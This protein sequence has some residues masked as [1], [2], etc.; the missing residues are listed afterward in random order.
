MH[1][2]GRKPTD[3]IHTKQ[4][5]NSKTQRKGQGGGERS[6]RLLCVPRLQETAHPYFSLCKGIVWDRYSYATK[7]LCDQP[8]K[9]LNKGLHCEHIR[10]F[11]IVPAI[12][13]FTYKAWPDTQ[14]TISTI[15]QQKR[16]LNAI[17]AVSSIGT[18]L[19]QDSIV[20]NHRPIF[21]LR[22][23]SAFNSLLKLATSGTNS[24]KGK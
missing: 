14:D 3:K 7:S 5:I 13:F 11:S 9:A 19:H 22:L 6:E 15:V 12:T 21:L 8:C 23:N 1:T 2:S 16:Y 24:N 20:T 4:T 18:Y 10:I 17:F